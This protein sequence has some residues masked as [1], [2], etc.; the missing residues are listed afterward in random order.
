MAQV[1][2]VSVHRDTHL[3]RLATFC[4]TIPNHRTPPI[5]RLPPD[6]F[7][8]HTAAS[9]CCPKSSENKKHNN[10]IANGALSKTQNALAPRV[11]N[12][13]AQPWRR[14]VDNHRGQAV[15]HVC[16]LSRFLLRWRGCFSE[17][18]FHGFIQICGESSSR[19]LYCAD[20]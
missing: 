18:C 12:F 16:N 4:Q 11:G 8:D 2:K 13:A 10:D 20:R 19:L 3:L 9:Q 17:I 15:T 5:P 1:S 14:S 7:F 6:L